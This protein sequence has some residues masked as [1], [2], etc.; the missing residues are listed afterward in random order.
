MDTIGTALQDIRDASEESVIQ[1][2]DQA[3]Q[4]VRDAGARVNRAAHSTPW[5]FVGSAA[6]TAM[7]LGFFA[8]RRSK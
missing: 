5:Y 3:K 4:S 2:A 6:A 7:V 8:G 1:I